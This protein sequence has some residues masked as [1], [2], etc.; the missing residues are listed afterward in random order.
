MADLI[1]LMEAGRTPWRRP[2]RADAGHH[3]NLVTGRR[4]RGSN[5]VL[6]SLGMHC[7]G[8]QLPF[9]CGW[10]EAR[11]LGLA[12]RRGTRGA[13]ILR[14]MRARPETSDPRATG[15]RDTGPSAS[16]PRLPE[17]DRG[18]EAGAGT[19]GPDQPAPRG[20]W[21]GCRPVVVFNAADLVG[22]DQACERLRRRIQRWRRAA[23][24]TLPPEPERLRRACDALT[25][26]PVPLLEGA[27]LACYQPSADRIE[28]PPS[29]RFE[30]AA[31]R[32]AT[33]AHEAI[34]STGHDSRLGRDLSGAFG[35]TAYAREE[36][37]AELGAVLLGERLAIGSDTR[38]H[39]A[40]LQHWCDLLRETPRL[41]LQI[42]SDARRAADLI[43]PDAQEANEASTAGEPGEEEGG[44]DQD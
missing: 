7:R 38:N 22:D 13:M 2:W 8:S 29:E 9:W 36:L 11:Q 20:R 24:A 16:G 35:S 1:Q 25:R 4:Y 23:G 27:S 14:P 30:S 10:G 40:Y 19:A 5:P 44:L 21:I 15:P 41:L 28:L 34:H 6:L 31:A 39:A 37:V 12:P 33:W 43:V 32:L 3:I 18:C 17:A 42:L 26:W